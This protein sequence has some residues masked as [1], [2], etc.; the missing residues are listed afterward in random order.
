MF[1]LVELTYPSPVKTNRIISIL[2]KRSITLRL[3]V[4]TTNSPHSRRSILGHFKYSNLVDLCY[5]S[6]EDINLVCPHFDG[7]NQG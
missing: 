2:V 3:W 1:N 5:T 4:G 6:K 7:V